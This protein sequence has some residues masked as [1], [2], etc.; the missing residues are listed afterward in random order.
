MSEEFSMEDFCTVVFD[1]FFLT[2]SAREN[3]LRHVMKLVW[4][5][6]PKLP[7]TRL[8]SI[9]KGLQPSL[10]QVSFFLSFLITSHIQD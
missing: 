8:T 10:H 9:M 4:Y 7:A 5:I 3:V 1:E 2:N 6:H